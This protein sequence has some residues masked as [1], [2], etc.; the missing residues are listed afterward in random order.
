MRIL[1]VEDEKKVGSFIKR[2]LEAANY[3]VDVERDGEAGLRRLLEVG[4]DL[5]IL[6]VMLPKLDGLAVMKEIRQRRVQ[7]PILLLTARIAVADKVAGLDLGADDYLTKPFAFE[8]L[9]ARVRALLRRGATGAPTVLSAADLR[10]DPATH[11]VTRGGRRIDLTS[12]EYA[13]LEFLLRRRDQVLSRAVIAQHV[14]GVDYD[15]F[16][17]VIDVYVNYLRKKIDS[18]FEPKL[19]HTVRGFGYV[20]KEEPPAP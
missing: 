6:D 16:T 5:V 7:V 8:E 2:G 4:Y 18:G 12:K 17:N 10:L 1:V 19:I 3:S 14:W 20:L 9:L 15:T 11:Q 13:L